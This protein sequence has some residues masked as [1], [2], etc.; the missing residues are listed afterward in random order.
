MKTRFD[1]TRIWI[2]SAGESCKIP[3]MD[4]RHLM[5][6]LRMFAQNPQRTAGMLIVDIERK[7]VCQENQKVWTPKSAATPDVR[8]CSVFNV[9]SMD[10]E[11]LIEYALNSPLAGAMLTILAERG[12]NA[13]NFM[14]SILQGC[15]AF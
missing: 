6:T 2:T 4:T 12:V 1:E 10:D 5:N 14:T 13:G 15:A 11:A 3:D 9:T 8:K 7:P